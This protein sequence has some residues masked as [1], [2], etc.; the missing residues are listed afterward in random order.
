MY[1]FVVLVLELVL[2]SEVSVLVLDSE[3]MVLVLVLAT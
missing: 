3:V 1:R 2:Y